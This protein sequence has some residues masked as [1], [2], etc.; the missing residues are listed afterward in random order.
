MNGERLLLSWET[1]RSLVLSCPRGRL[2]GVGIDGRVAA[3]L[4]AVADW[5]RGGRVV[6]ATPDEATV[7]VCGRSRSVEPELAALMS[8]R[9]EVVVWSLADLASSRY[10]GRPVVLPWNNPGPVVS[11]SYASARAD[12][13]EFYGRQFGT[14]EGSK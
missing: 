13:R 5:G 3:G 4:A 2:F 12:Y 14:N 11:H 6:V 10:E 1:V 7:F 9:P 8:A